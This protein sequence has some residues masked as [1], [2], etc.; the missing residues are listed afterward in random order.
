MFVNIDIPVSLPTGLTVPAE[1][2]LDS[3][4]SKR[5]FVQTSAGHFENRIVETGWRNNDRVQIVKGLREG[6]TVVAGGSFLVDSESRLQEV[7][8]SGNATR[9]TPQ[10]E[11]VRPH[12]VKAEH[13][14]KMDQSMRMDSTMKMDHSMN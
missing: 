10:A 7:S 5:V 3:G 14:I 1:A 4:L 2:I 12:A 9:I 13:A 11:P 6:D 8:D